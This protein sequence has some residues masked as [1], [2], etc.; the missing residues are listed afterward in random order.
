MLFLPNTYLFSIKSGRKIWTHQRDRHAWTNTFTGTTTTVSLP[1]I[2]CSTPSHTGLTLSILSR[3]FLT[4]PMTNEVALCN[5]NYPE[6]VFHRLDTKIDFHLS[7]QDCNTNTSMCKEKDKSNNIYIVVPYSKGLSESFRNVCN[8]VGS[9]GSF[10][11]DNTIEN[12]L[13]APKDKDITSKGGVLYRYK[14][15]HPG[16]RVEYI[17][18]TGGTFGDR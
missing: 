17:G 7:L 16:C 13:M 15:D 18:E 10:W 12:L 14:Y 8:K 4:R 3:S 9:S 11:E 6:W 2:L 5:C 1:N